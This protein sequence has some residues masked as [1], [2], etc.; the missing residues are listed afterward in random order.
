MMVLLI[1]FHFAF[2]ANRI[3]PGKAGGR[4]CVEVED[5]D[6]QRDRELHDAEGMMLT[7]AAPRMLASEATPSSQGHPEM[8]KVNNQGAALA[9]GVCFA[10]QTDAAHASWTIGGLTI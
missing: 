1:V 3:G 10:K 6:C 4:T 7:N 5:P 9:V 2:Q 8:N